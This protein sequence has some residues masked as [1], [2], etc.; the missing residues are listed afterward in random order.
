M[1]MMMMILRFVQSTPVTML[2][3]MP[4]P[5]A[6]RRWQTDR[7]TLTHRWTHDDSIYRASITSRD[8]NDHYPHLVQELIGSSRL[9]TTTS[10]LTSHTRDPSVHVQ[11]CSVSTLNSAMKEISSRQCILA[12]LTSAVQIVYVS[13]TSWLENTWRNGGRRI[14]EGAVPQVPHRS[15][16]R[17]VSSS[18]NVWLT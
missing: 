8:K 13:H 5:M 15:P 12:N 17:H 14:I 1:M 3:H 18:H 2:R 7:H 6:I 16:F 4:P 10:Q 9:P 11:Y